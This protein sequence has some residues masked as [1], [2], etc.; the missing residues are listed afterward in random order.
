MILFI[1]CITGQEKG[2]PSCADKKRKRTEDSDSEEKNVSSEEKPDWNPN[3][4]DTANKVIYP[5]MTF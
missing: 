1:S 2:K 5:A 3:A 4:F